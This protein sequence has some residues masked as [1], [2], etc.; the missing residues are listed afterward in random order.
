MGERD[1]RSTA[2]VAWTEHEGP[3]R[4]PAGAAS[5]MWTAT[6]ATL[7]VVISAIFMTDALC[8]DHRVWVQSLALLAIFGSVAAIVGLTRGWASAPLLTM[9]V[10]VLGALIGAIDAEH[11][12]VRGGLIAAGFLVALAFSGWLALRQLP[13]VGWDRRLRRDATFEPDGAVPPATGEPTAARP[14]ALSTEE[15]ASTSE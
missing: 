7:G 15:V 10:A 1:W 4:P 12:P 9:G 6:A 2:V 13:Q 8:P 11:S 3:G 14:T 5:W